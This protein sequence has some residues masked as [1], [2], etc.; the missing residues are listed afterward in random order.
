[1]LLVGLFA[2]GEQCSASGMLGML[3]YFI[4]HSQKAF[5][6]KWCRGTVSSRIFQPWVAKLEAMGVKM[7]TDSRVCDILTAEED[8]NRVGR[9]SYQSGQDS[10]VESMDVDAVIF[11]VGIS[12]MKNIVKSSPT[13][14]A[15]PQFRNCLNLS[16]I[17]CCAVRLYFDRR[18]DIEFA[19]NA[20]FGFPQHSGGTG[21]TYFSL[22][23]LHDEYADEEKSVV[24]ID[25]YHGNQ[26]LVM[27]DEEIVKE[28]QGLLEAAESTFCDAIVED[29]SVVRIPQGVTH[30]RPGSYGDFLKSKPSSLKNVFAAGDW[31][32]DSFMPDGSPHGSFSQEKALVSG[33]AAANAALTQLGFGKSSHAPIIALE[34]DEPHVLAARKFQRAVFDATSLLP[35]ADFFMM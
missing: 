21:W 16:A 5:D 32:R 24:E 8:D 28:V 11:A 22:N 27:S 7:K 9:V 18:V 15:R 30:F 25:F 14:A 29:F 31:I 26:Y 4:L 10:S 3:T 12:G 34:E 33:I 17:D 23:D 6:V 35:G 2:P 1:M 19:S 13:L 20:C